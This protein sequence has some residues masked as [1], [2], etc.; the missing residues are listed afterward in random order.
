MPDHL[1]EVIKRVV[2]GSCDEADIQAIS[3]ALQSGQI[4]LVTGSRAAGIAGDATNATVITSTA[5]ENL[6][7]RCYSSKSYDYPRSP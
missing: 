3:T 5:V 4:S 6:E 1:E 2:A 7:I